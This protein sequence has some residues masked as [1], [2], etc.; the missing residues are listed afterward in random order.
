M[1]PVSDMDDVDEELKNFL[2]YV[3]SGKRST[4]SQGSWNVRLKMPEKIKDGS[5]LYNLNVDVE[6]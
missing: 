3:A 2:L 5:F 1:N 6:N 4:I